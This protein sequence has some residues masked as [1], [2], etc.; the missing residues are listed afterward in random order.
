MM[1]RHEENSYLFHLPEEGS[2]M[3]S[4]FKNL[5]SA[6]NSLMGIRKADSEEI[7][8]LHLGWASKLHGSRKEMNP[9]TISATSLHLEEL[10]AN[11]GRRNLAQEKEVYRISS[12]HKHKSMWADSVFDELEEAG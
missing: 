12:E 8:Q 1:K 4:E 7:A 6:D 2:A 3:V 5:A 9:D 10:Y 11:E